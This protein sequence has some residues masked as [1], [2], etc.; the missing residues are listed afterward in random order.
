MG[1]DQS[2][3]QIG[4]VNYLQLS[5][6]LESEIEK[7]EEE[8]KDMDIST[9][10]TTESGSPKDL[11]KLIILD[12]AA[13]LKKVLG[14]IKSRSLDSGFT[15]IKEHINSLLVFSYKSDWIN[16]NKTKQKLKFLI[17]DDNH[18]AS[19]SSIST[20]D[21][22]Q[23]Q[24]NAINL[25]IQG[26]PE[27]VK[28]QQSINDSIEA[29]PIYKKKLLKKNF[30]IDNSSEH[31]FFSLFEAFKGRETVIAGTAKRPTHPE[32]PNLVTSF[33]VEN[34]CI[35]GR[36]S[37]LPSEY[38]SNLESSSLMKEVELTNEILK[39]KA[40]IRELK[41]KV[42]KYKERYGQDI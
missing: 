27:A 13:S 42:I 11:R 41:K 5:D 14:K 12:L 9:H 10:E 29:A 8:F 28:E 24:I 23:K 33:Q 21:N 39:L 2:S 16:Y 35:K 15:Q 6:M 36:L 1:C 3:D 34:F 19:K 22:S 26:T 17:E 31:T 32:I 37:I 25:F 38:N 30:P 4:I 7:I 18:H 20:L 40:K